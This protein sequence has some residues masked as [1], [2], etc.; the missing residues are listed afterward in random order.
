MVKFCCSMSTYS[1]RLSEAVQNSSRQLRFIVLASSGCPVM[2]TSR[3]TGLLLLPCRGTRHMIVLESTS[4]PRLVKL[5]H[6][7]S[8]S[9]SF[10]S[11][12]HVLPGKEQKIPP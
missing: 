6:A 2:H 3:K 12:F 8:G 10:R 9:F 7:Y 4:V 11:L 1:N 5:R